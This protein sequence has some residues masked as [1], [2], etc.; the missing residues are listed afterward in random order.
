MCENEHNGHKLTSYGGIMPNINNLK[1]K[2]NDFYNKIIEFKNNISKIINKL[3]DLMYDVDNYLEIFKDI[4]NSYENKK[5]NYSILQN[6][7][8]IIKYN[9]IFIQDLNKIIDEKNIN[10]KFTD[11]INLYNK[12]VTEISVKQEN[13]SKNTITTL[14]KP[15]KQVSD[16]IELLIKK[17]GKNFENFYIKN[18]KKVIS[19]KTNCKYNRYG[20]LELKDGRILYYHSD[21]DKD[22]NILSVINLKTNEFTRLKFYEGIYDIIQMDDCKL[23]L[24]THPDIKIINIKENEIE[25]IKSIP[26]ICGNELCELSN[27]KILVRNYNNF[28]IYSYEN[29][30]LK[31]Q[32]E[33]DISKPLKFSKSYSDINVICVINE[34]EIAIAY[35]EDGAIW[36]INALLAF[37]DIE[38]NKKIESFKFSDCHIRLGLINEKVMII[39][40]NNKFHQINLKNHSIKKLNSESIRYSH[41]V[42]FILPLNEK[43][44]IIE[45]DYNLY[46]CE[47][48]GNKIKIIAEKEK[49]S[50]TKLS[51]TYSK[52]GL[53]FKQDDEISKI[54]IYLYD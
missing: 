23:I 14:A 13:E 36:G 48:E 26:N 31:S 49:K 21:S 52:N 37:Y 33:I 34:N 15:N 51:S 7:N 53:I 38:K 28:Y 16:D 43:Q 27:K 41:L 40:E 35:R 19:F 10:N 32:K 6:I 50:S 12:M 44:F 1:N 42:K 46:Q 20:T 4:I 47:L 11:T 5:R 8:E 2:A 3:N 29:N 54:Y 18:L 30:D 24:K 45:E 17:E 39:W 22:K 9:D 25:I